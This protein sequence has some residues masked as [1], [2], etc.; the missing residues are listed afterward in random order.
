MTY[1]QENQSKKVVYWTILTNQYI[2]VRKSFDQN[3]LIHAKHILL[4]F[5]LSLLYPA[6]AYGFGNYQ[7]KNHFACQI[8]SKRMLG[9]SITINSQLDLWKF[10]WT[11][12]S[13]RNLNIKWFRYLMWFIFTTILEDIPLLLCKCWTLYA[14]W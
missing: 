8:P 12:Q 10:H 3:S 14:Y 7:W 13:C 1:V 9:Q 11:G 5:L 6:Q 4:V 2:H